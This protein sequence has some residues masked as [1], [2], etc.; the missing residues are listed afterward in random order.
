MSGTFKRKR[1]VQSKDAM[2][3]Q[4]TITSLPVVSVPKEVKMKD[5]D[6][7]VQRIGSHYVVTIMRKSTWWVGTLSLKSI[8][9]QHAFSV[10]WNIIW[11]AQPG[12]SDEKGKK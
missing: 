4:Y 7:I 11:D 1:F 8:H 5:G 6:A 9:L 10:L 3:E 2:K 12:G